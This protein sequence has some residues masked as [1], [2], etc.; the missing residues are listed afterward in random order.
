MSPLSLRD[1][2]SA[3]LCGI[4]KEML[5]EVILEELMKFTGD[6]TF[7]AFELDWSMLPVEAA[8]EF[9]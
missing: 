3:A 5:G 6:S 4:A 1:P 9:A 8:L 7:V 2:R